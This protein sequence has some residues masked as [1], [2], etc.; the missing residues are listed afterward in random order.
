MRKRRRRYRL[1]MNADEARIILREYFVSS[2]KTQIARI[3]EVGEKIRSA[4]MALKAA[5]ESG[6]LPEW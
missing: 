6:K 5:K 4:R 3:Q 1:I 2:P